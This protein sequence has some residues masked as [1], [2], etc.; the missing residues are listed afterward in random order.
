MNKEMLRE[1]NKWEEEEEIQEK[2]CFSWFKVVH[3]VYHYV[4][5]CS[6]VV[7]KHQILVLNGSFCNYMEEE[8]V[9]ICFPN[10]VTVMNNI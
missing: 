2:I 1:G 10:V 8:Q 9:I 4:I 6:V 5:V 3:F 7:E